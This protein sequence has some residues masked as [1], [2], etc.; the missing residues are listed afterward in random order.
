[1]SGPSGEI[2]IHAGRLLAEPGQPAT[3]RQSIRIEGGNITAIAD[4]FIIP[5]VGAKLIDLKDRFVLP[6]LIDC[7]VHLTMQLGPG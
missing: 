2:V 5:P 4:G 6:G 1:M 3:T 7:H